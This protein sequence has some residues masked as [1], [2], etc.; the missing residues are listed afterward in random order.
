RPHADC[1]SLKRHLRTSVK[2][3]VMAAAAAIGGLT[4]CVRPPRP[5]RPSKL[6]LE[7]DAQR[8]PGCS[9]SGFIPRHIEHP[10]SRQSKPAARKMLCR[11]SCSA[12]CL[13]ACDPGTT[14]A[15]TLELTLYPLA[16]RAAE[17]KSSRRELV[18]EPMNTRS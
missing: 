6:R 7:V 14:M 17:R 12:A 16:T 13:T 3:P 11:P 2:C 5:C 1:A 9:M 15:R 8:S 10:D 4:R 18:Q